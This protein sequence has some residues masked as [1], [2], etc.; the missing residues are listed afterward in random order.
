MPSKTLIRNFKKNSQYHIYNRGAFKKDVF[1]D[2]EDYKKF[3]RIFRSLIKQFEGSVVCLTFCLMPNHYHFRLFQKDERDVSK[4]MHLLTT[5][6]GNYFVKKYEH[7]G[8]LF[9][10]P[11]RMNLLRTNKDKKKIHNYILNNPAKAGFSNWKH[12]GLEP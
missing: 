5:R 3:C 4:F 1:I 2:E 10:G 9:Q 11:Y 8:R 6:Y 7:S 12:V